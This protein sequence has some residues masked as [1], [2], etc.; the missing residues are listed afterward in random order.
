M[1]RDKGKK[2]P[3]GNLRLRCADVGD[4]TCAW[5]T[6]GRDDAEIMKQMEQHA[7]EVHNQYSLDNDARN[8]IRSMIH[9]KKA[10]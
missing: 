8:R 1:A 7:R 3:Q 6:R 5:E 10:A 2:P 4:P 9:A